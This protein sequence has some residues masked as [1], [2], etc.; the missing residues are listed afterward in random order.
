MA[1]KTCC[2]SHVQYEAFVTKKNIYKHP[3]FVIHSFFHSYLVFHSFIF[4]MSFIY[5]LHSYLFLHS[6]KFFHF[7]ML[8]FFKFFHSTIFL[9]SLKFFHSS[10]S[11]ILNNGVVTHLCVA[12]F[13]WCVAKLFQALN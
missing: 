10:I 7:F 6:L 9:N 1:P 12:S 11:V 13:F 3:S 4:I 5:I 2:H 8:P